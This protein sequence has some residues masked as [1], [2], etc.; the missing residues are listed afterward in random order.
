MSWVAK[1]Q[2][3]AV[4]YVWQGGQE[5]GNGAVDVLTGKVCACGKL[6]DTIAADIH[7]YPSTADFGDPYKNFIK[8]IFMWATGISKLLRRIKCFNPLDMDY[9]IQHLRRK[10]RFPGIQRMS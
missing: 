4:I 7:D 1:Y 2:P 3:Q 5:G 8:K 9:P 6:T 10:P